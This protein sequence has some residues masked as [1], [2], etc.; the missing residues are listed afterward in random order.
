M[1]V[2]HHPH[3]LRRAIV[4]AL[5]A[6]VLAF[7]VTL[8]ITGGIGA[9]SSAQQPTGVPTPHT[10]INTR[11]LGPLMSNP[12]AHHPFTGPFTAPIRLPWASAVR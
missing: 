6:A 9:L 8:A 1:H 2:L 7:A 5:I 10:A 4:A 3:D 11:A 12:F